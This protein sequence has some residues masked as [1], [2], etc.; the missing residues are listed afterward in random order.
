MVFLGSW[1]LSGVSE[2]W[3]KGE[4]R[5]VWC[6]F[7]GFF[8]GFF[9]KVGEKLNTRSCTYLRGCCGYNGFERFWLGFS[10]MINFTF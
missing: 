4:K 5:G 10:L 6:H 2:K 8:K 3:K 9:K 1:C 7:L